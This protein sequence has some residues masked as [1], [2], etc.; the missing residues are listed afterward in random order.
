[1]SNKYA[2]DKG[3]HKLFESFRRSLTEIEGLEGEA[4]MDS[5]NA[6][7]YDAV[8]KAQLMLDNDGG[9]G[10]ANA[11]IQKQL[12][13]ATQPISASDHDYVERMSQVIQGVVNELRTLG[14]VSPI[15]NSIA[16]I[17]SDALS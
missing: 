1:M 5:F 8:T 9:S 6:T 15:A 17:L 12:D 2:T 14:D 11:E 3:M 4:P 10:E 7:M 16:D 13:V